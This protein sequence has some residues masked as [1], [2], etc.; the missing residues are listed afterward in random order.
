[1]AGGVPVPYEYLLW[2]LVYCGIYSLIAMLLALWMF[3]DRDL[4]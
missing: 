4:A 1:M 3:E 2:T